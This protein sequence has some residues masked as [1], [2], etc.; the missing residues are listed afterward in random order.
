MTGE[1]LGRLL[2]RFARTGRL[3]YDRDATADVL[4]LANAILKRSA[5]ADTPAGRELCD[6]LR[7]RAV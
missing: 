5:E 2:T 3:P 4:A 1:E 6:L 7:K